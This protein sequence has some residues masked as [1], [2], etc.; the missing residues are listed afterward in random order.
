TAFKFLTEALDVSKEKEYISNLKRKLIYLRYLFDFAIANNIRKDF[1]ALIK[2]SVMNR[3][4]EEWISSECRRRLETLRQSHYDISLT[5]FGKS[6]IMIRRE[7]V[8]ENDWSK[9]KWKLIFIHLLLN[10]KKGLTKDKIIDVFYPE[11]NIESA[12][13]IFYQRISKFRNL[14]RLGKGEAEKQKAKKSG[15][16][17]KTTPPIIEYEDGILSLN[18]DLTYY[19]DADE[20]ENSY[21]LSSKENDRQ[22]RSEYMKKAL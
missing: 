22:R 1:I 4:E 15:K 11:T 12:D 16:E 18:K 5:T 7:P 2:D 8:P 6:E 10:S 21:K 19:I 3:K 17:L 20:F 9:K 14:I 13:N